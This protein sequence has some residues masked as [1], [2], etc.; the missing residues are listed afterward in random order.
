MADP[1]TVSA[2]GPVPAIFITRDRDIEA[3]LFCLRMALEKGLA[4]GLRFL[5]PV[6]SD[7]AAARFR[8]ELPPGLD[9]RCI[10]TAPDF[11]NTVLALAAHLDDAPTVFFALSDR[12]PIKPVAAETFD[13][14]RRQAA[15]GPWDA[16]RL[17]HWRETLTDTVVERLPDGTALRASAPGSEF[18]SWHPQF[19]SRGFFDRLADRTRP[20]QS[21]HHWQRDVM[22]PV[23]RESRGF[24]V[25]DTQITVF[26]ETIRNGRECLNYLLRDIAARGRMPATPANT[27]MC[28]LAFTHSGIPK[29]NEFHQDKTLADLRNRRLPRLPYTVHSAG[30]T[31]SKMLTRWLY[32]AVPAPSRPANLGVAHCHWRLPP[33]LLHRNHTMVYVFGDPVATVLSFF[34]R[35]DRRHDRH[36][37]GTAKVPPQAPQPD[38]AL[39]AQKN[40]EAPRGPLTAEDDA[41]S[42]VRHGLDLFR[43]EEHLNNHLYGDR[44]YPIVFLRYETL[45]RHEAVLR[46]LF[47]G[48]GPLP[49]HQPRAARQDDLPPDAAAAYEALYDGHRRRLAALPDVFIMQNGQTRVLA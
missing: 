25:P 8:V 16:V 15:Q 14:L 4:R 3:A 38:F 23:V 29:V 41:V 13:A 46:D 10:R 2:S 1:D 17:C 40:A 45:W 7:L 19:L 24:V 6:Q 11:G 5:I 34:A 36:G 44:P 28:T 12:Y 37:F 26:E 47:A 22:L 21:L 33:V 42:Y 30:G 39:Q 20:G 48:T 43:L 35:R 27:D 49:P 32:D 18:G 9:Y 31:G